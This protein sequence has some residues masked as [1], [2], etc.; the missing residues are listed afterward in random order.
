M[1]LSEAS[2]E[3]S[4]LKSSKES[5]LH[6]A[7]AALDKNALQPVLMHV[8]ETSGYT[9]YVLVVSGRSMRQV[10]AIAE[11]IQMAMKAEAQDAL[12]A[13][14]ERGGHWMLL[15]YGD[16]VIHVFFHPIREY[17]DLE[18]MF[19]D[20]PRIELDVPPEQ[21]YAEPYSS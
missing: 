20:S 6:A 4:R 5:A 9:D 12:G 14:G 16:V 10:Q 8:G 1:S 21:Q 11:A 15:D 19:G 7:K 13:E 17:Y 18:G 3:S 2:N